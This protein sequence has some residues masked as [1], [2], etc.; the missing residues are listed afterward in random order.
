M[1]KLLLLFAALTLLAG[2]ASA[3]K[4]DLG[5]GKAALLTVPDSWKSAA[6][7]AGPSGMPAMGT[8]VRYVT[9]SGSNDAVIIT[10]IAVPD[11]RFAEA[12][13]L[14]AMIEEATQQFAAG[15]VEGKA[16]LKEFKVGGHAGY[17]VAFTDSNLVGKPTAKEDYKTLTSCF[18]YLGDKVMLTATIFSDDLNGKPYAE[19]LHLLKSISLASGKGAL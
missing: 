4:L 16:V 13:N 8:N 17:C 7:P 11:D 9:K 18:V 2:A 10:L 14:K 1:K 3:E 5:E 12:D 15:S 19:A 6:M